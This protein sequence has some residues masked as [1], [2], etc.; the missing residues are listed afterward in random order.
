M[1]VKLN[2]F[3]TLSDGVRQSE[4]EVLLKNYSAM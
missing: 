1:V 3:V 4:N 2:P